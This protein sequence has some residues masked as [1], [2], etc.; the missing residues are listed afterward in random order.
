MKG[1]KNA[2]IELLEKCKICREFKKT[3]P[4]PRVGMPVANSFNEVV[5]LDLK[6]LDNG[7]YILWMVDMFSR[8]L[9]GVLINNKKPETI[10]KAIINCWVIGDG[11]GPGHPAK[12]FYSDNGGE[13]LNDEVLN[14]AATL[15][16]TI[17]MTSAR[18]PWQNGLVERNHAT[19]DIV[20]E[21]MLLD[22][23]DL[24]PQEAINLAALAKNSEVNRS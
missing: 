18:A 23:P 17:K 10:V 24:T 4:R 9:K 1:K 6:V 11:F 13:F 22:N 7:K 15:D 8:V 14:L 21:K 2:V 5:G 20:Y 12:G 19:V 3:P 16:T